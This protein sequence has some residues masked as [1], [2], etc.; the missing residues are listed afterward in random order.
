MTA[1][2]SGAEAEKLGIVF[3][4]TTGTIIDYKGEQTRIKLPNAIAGVV[5]TTIGSAAFSKKNLESVELPDSVETI[6]DYAFSNNK[7][8]VIEL[9][10]YLKKIGKRAF[11][12]NLLK[13]LNIPDCVKFVGE[14]AFI[15]NKFKMISLAYPEL[16]ANPFDNV[17]DVSFQLRDKRLRIARDGISLLDVSTIEV[18]AIT[19][20]STGIIP[21]EVSKLA[22][23]SFL[24]TEKSEVVLPSDI[25]S[26]S[27]YA[28]DCVNVRK[29]VI[30]NSVQYIAPFAFETINCNNDLILISE[31]GSYVESYARKNNLK[32]KSIRTRPL[33]K[34]FHKA[35]S[36]FSKV[37]P[38]SIFTK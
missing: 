20:A 18:I 33:G 36:L 22:S 38:S 21:C 34:A 5:V 14:E 32:F 30:P 4:N 17:D 24:C 1:N 28:F 37:S 3:D 25:T 29:I 35:G 13:V 15:R 8:E 9:P 11:A 6:S 27:S 7:L 16:D 2:I 19:V 12:H 31:P 23:K 10:K 26:I